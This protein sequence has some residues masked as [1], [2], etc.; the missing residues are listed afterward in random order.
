MFHVKQPR[1]K[2]YLFL[3]CFII[4]GASA[5]MAQ[6]PQSTPD[7]PRV[8][9]LWDS[10]MKMPD[11]QGASAMEKEAVYLINLARTNPRLYRDSVVQPYL[12]NNP[13]LRSTYSNSLIATLSQMAAVATMQAHKGLRG[14]ALGHAKDLAKQGSISHTGSDGRSA[15]DRLGSIGIQCGSECVHSSTYG[16]ANEMVLSLLIDQGIASLGHRK[17]LLAPDNSSVGVGISVK[18][19]MYYMVVNMACR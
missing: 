15:G 19:P 1:V 5:V 16:N 14:I 13:D 9:S 11:I 8:S 3:L 7:Y 6:A 2:T 17:A 4:N 12:K 18:A 10:V